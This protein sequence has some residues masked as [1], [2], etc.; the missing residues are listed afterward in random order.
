MCIG[1][2][3]SVATIKGQGINSE[4]PL[5]NYKLPE[6]IKKHFSSYPYL[7][8][9][10][11]KSFADFVIDKVNSPFQP[12]QVQEGDSI[13]LDV[14]FC[15]YFFSKLH[16]QISNKYV[17]IV[18]GIDC[19]VPGHYARYLDD[20]KIIVWF[21]INADTKNHP[22]LIHIPLGLVSLYNNFA[23]T[24]RAESLS[25]VIANKPQEKSKL[26][27]MNFDIRTNS[28][29]RQEVYNFFAN[30]SFCAV[31]TR[32]PWQEYLQEMANYKFVICPH[33]TGLD[34]F[35]TWE[36]LYLDCI[37]IVKASTL[38]PLYK[39]LPVLIID[40]WNE[41]T[42]QFLHI[43]YAEMSQKKYNRE[44][45]YADYWYDMINRYQNTAKKL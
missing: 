18:H 33:G 17:L 37:P 13:Y 45:M 22:K 31:G 7:S 42:E 9:N 11:F 19:S 8:G 41:I 4:I 38:D 10:T 16:P 29:I 39:D 32:K 44:K 40:D 26:L 12:A 20:E 35:R 25:K 21:A 23:T 15:D 24:K 30:K 2:L 1:M 6:N 14:T 34:C 5:P 3:S 27:Y 28:G 43:Q 36:A